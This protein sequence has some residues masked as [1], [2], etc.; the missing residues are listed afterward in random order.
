[1][2]QD[3]FELTH[4]S[5]KNCRWSALE[6]VMHEEWIFDTYDLHGPL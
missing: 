3:K 2:I 4:E 1:M 5:M 6:L